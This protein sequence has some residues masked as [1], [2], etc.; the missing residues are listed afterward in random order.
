MTHTPLNKKKL[1]KIHI[2]RENPGVTSEYIM[3]LLIRTVGNFMILSSLFMIGKTFYQPV[4]EEVRYLINNQIEKEYVVATESEVT[5]QKIIKD[6]S[7]AKQQGGLAKV[8][9]LKQ[10][11]L[12]NPVNPEFSIVVPKIGANAPILANVDA[13]NEAEYLEALKK[14]VAHTKGTAFP[15]EGGH[16]FFFAHS[17]DYIWNVGSYNAV[18][19]LLY[20]LEPGDEINLFYKGE[21]FVYIVRQK[22]IVNPDQVEYI[23]RKTDKEFITL[24]TCWPPGTTLQRQLVFAERVVE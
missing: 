19:Y 10:V 22:E 7:A 18:F 15:G 13:A 8:F 2:K 4:K 16:M 21:R 24:Q 9:N 6:F 20:K 3:I 5:N 1:E 14:G 23:T 11:E 17:T 12:L